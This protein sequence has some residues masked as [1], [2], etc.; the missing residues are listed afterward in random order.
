MSEIIRIGIFVGI[1]L[2]I[3]IPF[4]YFLLKLIYKNSIL[5]KI[6]TTMT[7]TI[8]AI[9]IQVHYSEHMGLINMIW[10][11][12][13]AILIV[14]AG[15][16]IIE[17]ILVKRAKAIVDAISKVAHGD[18]NVNIDLEIAKSNDELGLI[19]REVNLMSSKMTE[20]LQ[21]IM[22]VS[23]SISK[24]SSSLETDSSQMAQLAN[25]QAASVEEV[26]AT[27][28]QMAAGISQNSNNSEEAEAIAKKSAVKIDVN[29]KNVQKAT[30]ALQIISKR[31]NVITEIAFQTNILSLNAAIEASK[32]GKYGKGFN[33]VS[34]EIR[35]LS[36]RSK[37]AADE[38]D[39]IS[40]NSI[41]ISERT[42]RI[43]EQIVPDVK[44][45]YRI[46]KQISSSSKEQNLSA[47]Q[48]NNS[49]QQLNR[50][51]QQLAAVSQKLSINAEDLSEFSKMLIE[52]MNYFRKDYNDDDQEVKI[53]N[54]NE[55]QIPIK[56][57]PKETNLLQGEISLGD[58][59]EDYTVFS[60]KETPDDTGFEINLPDNNDE[61]FEKF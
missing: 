42:S 27:M 36:H 45:T 11:V 47:A 31:I 26:S 21:N 40:K 9:V 55:T 8:S 23:N 34:N 7:A 51:T 53:K 61:D 16:K 18:L 57:E 29:N 52:N 3:G 33:V 48:V 1:I 32:A 10:G 13:L 41:K 37:I 15:I 43:S 46:V 59:F 20:V 14:M 35:K 25:E 6:G 44:K 22:T 39:T 24:S 4:T 38:I 60:K 19:S 56:K 5:V 28:E 54:K 50:A 58:D 30:E 2:I 12:P 17:K 49:V